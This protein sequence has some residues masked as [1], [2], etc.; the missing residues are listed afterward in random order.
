MATLFRDPARGTYYAN[1]VGLD[2]RRRRKGLGVTDRHEAEAL[3]ANIVRDNSRARILGLEA[4]K[5]AS[6]ITFREFVETVYLPACESNLKAGTVDNY[7]DYAEVAVGE[8][9]NQYLSAIAPDD[10]LRFLDR[11]AV[12]GYKKGKLTKPYAPATVNRYKNFLS[13]VF[14]D[15]LDRE[16]VTRHPMKGR[17]R[18]KNRQENN[19][20]ERFLSPQEE[21][22]LLEFAVPWLSVL[23][24]FAL[25]TG[26]RRGEILRLRLQD[27]DREKRQARLRDP[28]SRKDQFVLLNRSAE[29]VLD[30]LDP[31]L[32]DGKVQ[33]W[34]FVNAKTGRPYTEDEVDHAFRAALDR[35]GLQDFHFHDLRHTAGT[36]MYQRTK[37]IKAVQR[38]LRHSSLTPTLRYVH[39]GEEDLRAAVESLDAVDDGAGERRRNGRRPL[40]NGP[41]SGQNVR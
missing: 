17:K 30:E 19:L 24:R 22:R 6:A 14:T 32:V 26:M 20:R 1:Y 34:V 25:A 27:V 29:G 23:V 28:K 40:R 12:S 33:P 13:G 15:A 21:R 16:L 8:F 18:F 4:T 41:K 39:D 35:A 7:R 37:D 10:V 2:G 3:L 36:R 38:F 31:F 5:Q 9:G 11:L